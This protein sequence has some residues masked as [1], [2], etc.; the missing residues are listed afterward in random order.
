M[1][2]PAD[3]RGASGSSYTYTIHTMPWRPSSGQHGNYIFA[4]AVNSVWQPVYI[5]QG[6]LQA[7]YDAALREDCVTSKGA[8]HYYEHLNGN[9]P[10]RKQEESDLISGNPICKWPSGCNG[11]D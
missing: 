11:H 2:N 10:D 6:D 8:T 9:E 1:S 7:R 4:K 5:G 3:W